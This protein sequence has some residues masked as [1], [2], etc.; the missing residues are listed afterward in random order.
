M[1][2]HQQQPPTAG[3]DAPPLDSLFCVGSL[4]VDPR[5]DEIVQNGVVTKLEPRTMRLLVCLAEHAGRILSVEQLLD[6]V[7][8]DVVVGPDSVYQAVAGLRRILRD[9]PKNPTYIANVV[10]RGYRLVAPVTAWLEAAPAETFAGPV[11]PAPTPAPGIPVPA[12]PA[13]APAGS[14]GR[15]TASPPLRADGSSVA[16]ASALDA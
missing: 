2:V 12:I 1:S 13:P 3:S 16:S 5:S 11:V 10:R 15:G 6:A 7:W 8:K 4:R 9:D 14:G